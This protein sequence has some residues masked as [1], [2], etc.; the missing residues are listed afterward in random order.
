[1]WYREQMLM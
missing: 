1:M